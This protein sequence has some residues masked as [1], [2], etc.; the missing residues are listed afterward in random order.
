MENHD[1]LQAGEGKCK[2]H[3][4][5]HN[6]SGIV[7]K[8]SKDA[9]TLRSRFCSPHNR[10]ELSACSMASCVGSY[11]IS[12]PRSND[13]NYAVLTMMNGDQ[14]SY[15]LPLS[16]F[17]IKNKLPELP[18]YVIYK[19]V[20]GTNVLK[21]SQVL[22]GMNYYLSVVV[23]K[24][25]FADWVPKSWNGV[26][27]NDAHDPHGELPQSTYEAGK[28]VFNCMVS[29]YVDV[30][31]LSFDDD[32]TNRRIEMATRFIMEGLRGG[33]QRCLSNLMLPIRTTFSDDE[34]PFA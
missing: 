10:S 12:T 1:C 29:C 4:G 13:A 9:M 11:G 20:H 31:G 27:P 22:D 25:D 24:V 23:V 2:K 7:S 32:D 16:V 5:T 19:I 30:G 14:W 15:K 8:K 34:V 33:W 3:K 17:Q 28:A 18:D 21:L 26:V 6:D